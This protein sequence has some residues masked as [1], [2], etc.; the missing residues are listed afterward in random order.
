MTGAEKSTSLH[1]RATEAKIM[2]LGFVAAGLTHIAEQDL[3]NAERCEH[4]AQMISREAGGG[5]RGAILKRA[6]AI[7]RGQAKP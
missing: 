4:W 6:V 5:V 1:H 3:D 7:L 2:G